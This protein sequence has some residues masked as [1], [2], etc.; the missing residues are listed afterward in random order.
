MLQKACPEMAV[1]R[2]H[3]YERETGAIHRQEQEFADENG[4]TDK[5]A[6]KAS[7][8]TTDKTPDKPD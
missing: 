8:K 1:V 2:F 4:T 5:T 7:D 6:D 3:A